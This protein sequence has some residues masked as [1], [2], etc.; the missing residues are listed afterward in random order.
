MQKQ[1]NGVR[2]MLFDGIKAGTGFM[3]S[4]EELKRIFGNRKKV[5]RI[6][7]IA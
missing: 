5:A 7:C 6:I 1:P 3:P 2:N 4:K